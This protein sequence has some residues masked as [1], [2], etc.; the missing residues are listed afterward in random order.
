MNHY[1]FPAIRGR[2]GQYEYYIVQC[3]MRL[4]PRLFYFDEAEIPKELRKLHTVDPAIVA[5]LVN[6]LSTKQEAYTLTPL[7]AVI[8]DAVI[9]EPVIQNVSE[10]GYIRIPMEARLIIR[11]GQHRR[12]AIK[13]IIAQSDILA[14]DTIPVMLIP[15]PGL[16]RANE[17]Y[18]DLHSGERKITK[19]RQILQDHGD[20]AILVRQLVDEVPIFQ[21]LVE[22]EKTTISN[23]ST[24]LFTL[25]AV[26]QA[27]EALLKISAQDTVSFEQAS[28]AHQFWL[29]SGE[30]IPEWRQIIARTTTAATLRQNYIHSHTV[31]LIAIGIAGHDL[32]VTHPVDWQDRLNVL[33]TVD[34][35]RENSKLWEGRAMVRGKMNKT[36]DSIN[37][38]ANAIKQILGLTLNERELALEKILYVS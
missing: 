2:Q 5:Q 26:Y 34:W 14:D 10:I 6:T 19:S 29:A 30:I 35:S 20:L 37:L 16:N 27:N 13:K 33:E 21:G 22:M 4:L 23:R 38:T 11:D 8:E 7:I 15:D 12:E 3:Q 28:L 1:M 36:R 9:F 31:A 25:S 17:I 18:L 32:I 24:S